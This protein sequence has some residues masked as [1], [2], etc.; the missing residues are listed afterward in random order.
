MTKKERLITAVELAGRW[1]L[2]DG[3]WRLVV[4]ENQGMPGMMTSDGLWFKPVSRLH[5]TGTQWANHPSEEPRS[6]MITEGES[7]G[8]EVIE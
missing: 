7:L 4:V 6:L 5:E 8:L 3:Q 1:I 2:D